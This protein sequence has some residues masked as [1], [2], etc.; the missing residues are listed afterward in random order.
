MII[1]YSHPSG[2]DRWEYKNSQSDCFK[3]STGYFFVILYRLSS[4]IKVPISVLPRLI[5]ISST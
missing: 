5:L 4:P 1:I 3:Q 2:M